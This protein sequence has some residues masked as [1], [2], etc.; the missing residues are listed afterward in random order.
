MALHALSGKVYDELPWRA[1]PLRNG[2]SL[3]SGGRHANGIEFLGFR[4]APQ[5]TTVREGG[6]NARHS[7]DKRYGGGDRRPKCVS[8]GVS[9]R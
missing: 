4:Y 3:V 8:K 6:T 2:S 1:D 7:L 9:S 5:K